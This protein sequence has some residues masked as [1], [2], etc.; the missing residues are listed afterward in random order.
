LTQAKKRA[1]ASL[2][3]WATEP[4]TRARRSE[5]DR[6]PGCA[7]AL[8]RV[9]ELKKAGKCNRT[10]EQVHKYLRENFGLKS[11]LSNMRHW[12]GERTGKCW[13]ELEGGGA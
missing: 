4:R 10:T 9:I 7:E 13:T 3:A 11:T 5:I 2:D 8:L 1:C 6:T 12:I